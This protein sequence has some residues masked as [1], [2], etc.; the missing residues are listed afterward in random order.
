MPSSKSPSFVNAGPGKLS[1]GQ[2]P[3]SALSFSVGG[4]GDLE[5][6]IANPVDAHMS[7]A[8]GIPQVNPNTGVPL[9]SSAGGP[10]DGESVMDALTALADLLPVRPDRLGYNNAAIPNSGLTNWSSAMTVGGQA[11]HGGFKSGTIAKITKYLTPAGSA[12]NQVVSGT[13]YPADR[14]VLAIYHTTN[15]DFT[16]V[17]QTT[18][19]A[20]VCLGST[21]PVGIPGASFVELTRSTGQADYTPTNTGIDLISLTARLPYLSSYPGGQYAPYSQNFSAFQLAKYAFSVPVTTGNSG[22][23]V[24]VQWKETYA[25]SLASIQPANLAANLN[26]VQCYSAPPSDAANY[27]NVVRLNVFVDALSGSGPT[28]GTITTSPTGTVTTSS[29]SGI[30]YYNSSGLQLNITSTAA[31]VFSNSF[32][33]N[34]G[35]SASVPSGFESALPVVQAL[36]GN[37]NG[38]AISYPLFDGSNVTNNVGGAAF[39]LA[40]PPD[41]TSVA[42]YTNAT[43]STILVGSPVPKPAFPA[44]TAVIRWRGSFT[45]PV[46]ITST[47]QYLVGPAITEPTLSTDVRDSFVAESYRFPATYIPGA[48]TIKP[49]GGNIFDSVNALATGEL[50]VLSGRLV[51]PTLNFSAAQYRPVQASRDYSA[52]YT[53]DAASTKRRWIR[54]FDTGI[55]RNTGKIQ[56][57]GLASAAFNAANTPDI[58]EIADHTGGAIVQIMVPGGTGWLDLGRSDG[59]PDNNKTLDFRGCKVSVVEGGGVTTVT[60]STGGTTTAPNS[61]GKYLLFVRVT[62]IKNGT[63]ETLNVQD[64]QWLPPT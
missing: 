15:D 38:P 4:T 5:A 58:N 43:Q 42:K 37:F 21:T 28:G 14:G 63:G 62:L 51:Y 35:A 27:D 7:S 49:T 56:L 60:Y 47:E 32:L 52:L 25:T 2:V 46:D 23:Y 22:S 8:I 12:G 9:L 30:Q 36:L 44:A 6:H 54:A 53:A 3:A 10:Y 61:E 11:I 18:L 45:G 57:T 41:P 50:Q 34:I 26:A 55:A 19:V 33:T 29:V 20:A 31:N 17:G 48:T 59:T 64:I 24:L 13:V 16:N 40:N 1:A 39:T